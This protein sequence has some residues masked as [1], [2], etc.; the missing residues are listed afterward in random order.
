VS[1]VIKYLSSGR[2]DRIPGLQ[3]FLFLQ[4]MDVV[5]TLLG[6]EVGLGEASPFIRYLMHLSPTVGVLASKIVAIALAAFCIRSGRYQVIRYVNYWY[7][8]LVVW[9]LTLILFGLSQK[10]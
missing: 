7:A 3:I 1:A 10:F 2:I 6:F 8:A 5:T 9:N 4:L